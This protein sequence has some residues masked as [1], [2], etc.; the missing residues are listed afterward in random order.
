MPQ[1]EVLEKRKWRRVVALKTSLVSVSSATCKRFGS[2]KIQVFDAFIL[3]KLFV[4]FLLN[5]SRLH[6][7]RCICSSPSLLAFFYSSTWTPS[8][9]CPISPS[10][11][12]LNFCIISNNVLQPSGCFG[13]VSRT[14]DGPQQSPQ[15]HFHSFNPSSQA[16]R[17]P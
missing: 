7:H 8:S 4:P 17:Q 16:T 6:K 11:T 5:S 12:I 3:P 2:S 13:E 15:H 9:S 14:P 10:G 1:K